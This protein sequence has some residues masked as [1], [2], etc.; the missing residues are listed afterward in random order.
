[1]IFIDLE[2]ILHQLSDRQ[3]GTLVDS[4]KTCAMFVMRACCK[5]TMLGELLNAKQMTTMSPI[6]SPCHMLLGVIDRF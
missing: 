5:S 3:S 6:P 4:S 2:E 1:M